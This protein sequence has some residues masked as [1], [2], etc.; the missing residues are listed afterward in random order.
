MTAS[1][2]SAPMRPARAGAA[3]ACA[4]AVA[5]GGAQ[6]RAVEALG[7][8]QPGGRR[9]MLLALADPAA[10][11]ERAEQDLVHALVE[12]REREPGLEMAERLVVIGALDELLQQGGVAGAQAAALGDQPA[13]ERRAALDREALEELARE[14]RRQ[15]AQALGRERRDARLGRPARSRS[16]R[17]S[18]RRDRGRRVA[19][20]STRRARLVEDGRGAC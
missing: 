5:P 7:V 11:G 15:R 9:Q 2:G 8:E 13:L 3:P 14:Q 6:R 18:S 4:R 10:P 16:H 12:R 17:P 20:A 19:P 1:G